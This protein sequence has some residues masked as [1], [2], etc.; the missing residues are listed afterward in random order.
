MKQSKQVDR[1]FLTFQYEFLYFAVKQYD[2]YILIDT[3]QSFS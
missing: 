1:I 3:I 2:L